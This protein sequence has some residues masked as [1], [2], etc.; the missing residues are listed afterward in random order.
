M[1]NIIIFIYL[2][3][4]IGLVN[5]TMAEDKVRVITTLTDLASLAEEIGGE[6]VEATALARGTQDPHRIEVLPSYMMKLRKAD[7]FLTVGMDLDMWALPLRDG[8]RN[9]NLVVTDCSKNIKRLEVPTYNLDPSY[10][11]IH[12]YGNPHYWLD[13]EN[14]KV[15]MQAILDGLQQVSPENYDYFKKNMDE[16]IAKLDEKIIVWK[17]LMEPVTNHKIIFYHNSWPYFVNRFGLNVVNFV[18]PK[19]GIPP[20]PLHTAKL[21][22]QVQNQGVRVLAMEP[23]FDDRVPNMLARES[24]AKV[25]KLAQSVGAVDE[26]KDY[27]SLFDYNIRI[28]LEAYNH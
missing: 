7:L 4:I 21:L 5:V 17:Q 11:D 18:E 20:S 24:E 13:P 22:N 28:L 16:F 10:G 23:Y 19:P 25:V 9:A 8:S 15:M 1:K 3:F 27:I 2:L 26:V 14:G 6:K 12:I